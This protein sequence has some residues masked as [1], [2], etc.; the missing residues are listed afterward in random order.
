MKRRLHKL[1]SEGEGRQLLWLF[2]ALAGT[3]LMF[4]AYSAISGWDYSWQDIIGLYLDGG[5]FA[6]IEKGHND[7]F[8]LIITFVGIFLFSALLISVFTN[9]F[10]NISESYKKGDARYRFNGHVLILGANHTLGAILSAL[11]DNS[12]YEGRDIVVM[13]TCDV[14]KLRDD[15]EN[16]LV[17]KEFSNRVTFYHDERIGEDH[18]AAAHADK[19]SVIYLIGED[20]EI[21]HDSTSIKSL[22]TLQKLCSGPGNPIICYITIESHS[23]LDVLQLMKQA[24]MPTRIQAE[25]IS[26]S[27]YPVEQLLIDSDFLPAISETDEEH[28]HVVIIGNSSIARAFA[29][30]TM[31]ICHYPN[32]NKGKNRTVVSFIGENMRR[33]MDDFTANH[34]NIFDLS[35][36]RYVSKDLTESWE[37]K[38]EFGDFLDIEW[39]F[40]DT[41]LSSSYAREL[42]SQW[43]NDSRQRMVI[44]ICFDDDSQNISAALHLPDEIYLKDTP[45]A[46]YQRQQ[47]ALVQEAMKTGRFG[48]LTYFGESAPR[49]DPLFLLRSQRGKRVNFI[50][51]L[52]YGNPPADSEDKAWNNLMHA[53]R[54]SSIASANFIPLSLRCFG[55]EA[56]RSCID[57]LTTKQLESLSEVEHRR[58]M[59]TVL[60]L[61]YKAV[62][63]PQRKD[64]TNYERLKDVE[65]IHLD[66]ASYDQLP[67]VSDKDTLIVSN[68][69][70]II[71]GDDIVLSDGTTASHRDA[72]QLAKHE[73]LNN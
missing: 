44:A 21:S 10:E 6:S 41:H 67:H 72:T 45:V 69:P 46:V 42:L 31:G 68:I 71:N 25:I 32:F 7:W 26:D 53:K 51:N 15:M 5:T 61:G 33:M 28:L 39:E 63:T 27:D 43:V 8:R 50:Y 52:E 22:K 19:A 18:L 37:P 38:K 59:S 49:H 13:T 40:I 16:L 9:I 36:Y 57:K 12:T 73:L 55:L 2:G 24:E 66:I 58:W 3:F 62:P 14:E 54:L 65:F 70:Y 34:Q 20:N 48:K 29:T 11:R 47:C 64:R 60:L 30:V 4:W 1:L 23:S 35:H 17:D 56:T